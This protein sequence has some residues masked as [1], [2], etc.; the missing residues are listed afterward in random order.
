MKSLSFEQMSQIEGGGY[1]SP[2][3]R[4]AFGLLILA[5]AL[6]SYILVVLAYAAV[7]RFCGHG[8]GDSTFG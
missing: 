4:N 5:Y 6:G 2:L 8:G 1:V 7:Y 3:C